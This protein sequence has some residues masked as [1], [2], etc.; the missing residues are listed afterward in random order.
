MLRR[1][2]SAQET[3]QLHDTA[4]AH[5][6]D[7]HLPAPLATT[8]FTALLLEQHRANFE[9]WHREDAARDPLAA[10]KIIAEV[11]R[12][13]DKLNQHRNDLVERMDLALLEKAGDQTANAPLHSETPGMMI[14]RLSILS[15]K[16]FHTAEEAARPEATDAHR[17]R[18]RQRL[19]LLQQQRSDLARCLDLLWNEVCSG[20]RRF[21]LYRQLKMYN[22]PELNP[23]LRAHN[24]PA[25]IASE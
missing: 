10:D 22:D 14:D 2:L 24:V 8:A 6:H 23:V 16:L 15:L 19:S 17:E 7:A 9:L 13:I 1:M 4:N 20:Q 11:K 3:L 25:P 18:N 12:A 5:W 21:K